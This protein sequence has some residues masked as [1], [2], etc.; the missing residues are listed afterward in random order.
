MIYSV[1]QR[2]GEMF[3]GLRWRHNPLYQAPMSETNATQI[4]VADFVTVNY[5]KNPLVGV[6]VAKVL[7]FYTEV[8]VVF[9]GIL[10]C[11]CVCASITCI[12]V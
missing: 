11:K 7:Q 9:A 8:H 12:C 2:Y 10:V 4:F 3:H 6:A 5:C 1:V